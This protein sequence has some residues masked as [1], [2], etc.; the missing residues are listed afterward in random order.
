MITEWGTSVSELSSSFSF[1]IPPSLG[2]V[3]LIK[4]SWTSQG[5]SAFW[6]SKIGVRGEKIG[7]G[8]RGIFTRPEWGKHFA[9]TG[10]IAA[11]ARPL[12]IEI[13]N[14]PVSV[15]IT[16]SILHCL[17]AVKPTD[18]TSVTEKLTSKQPSRGNH[19]SCF[20]ILFNYGFNGSMSL[21]VVSVY[22]SKFSD[23]PL[24]RIK[25]KHWK[26]KPLMR[27]P[28]EKL[29]RVHFPLVTRACTLTYQQYSNYK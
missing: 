25:L 16:Q 18:T 1:L 7:G 24:Q 4:H 12:H 10:T 20:F 22:F 17:T 21:T 11:H 26:I 23:C 15:R 13:P 28:C 8:R 29:L 19:F 9:R 14:D 3:L 2:K 27:R 5:L 6:P